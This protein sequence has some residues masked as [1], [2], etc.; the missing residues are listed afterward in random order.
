MSYTHAPCSNMDFLAARLAG[1]RYRTLVDRGVSKVQAWDE[2]VSL[3]A[4]HHPSWPVPLAKRDA[5]RTVGALVLNQLVTAEVQPKQLTNK[6]P[7]DL[8]VDL[9][10]PGMPESMRATTR[11]EG[12]GHGAVSI[13]RGA[14]KSTGNVQPVTSRFP[15]ARPST[16]GPASHA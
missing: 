5:A 7:L 2:A 4:G 11:V 15:I 12:M 8:L 9:A 10:R 13:F 14:S 16:A 3:F 6:A 1:Q